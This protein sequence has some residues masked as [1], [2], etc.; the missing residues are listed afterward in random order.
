MRTDLQKHNAAMNASLRTYKA[1][2]T[3]AAGSNAARRAHRKYS[4]YLAYMDKLER[5]QH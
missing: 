2:M 1:W 4:K 3:A 5:S